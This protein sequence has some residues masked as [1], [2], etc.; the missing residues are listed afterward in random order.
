MRACNTEVISPLCAFGRGAFDLKGAVSLAVVGLPL[1]QQPGD[2]SALGK[3]SRDLVHLTML[4]EHSVVG[5]HAN[6]DFS[7]YGL[8]N[9]DLDLVSR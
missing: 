9:R 7:L 5:Y 8:S 6:V 3:L 1:E 2:P 4:V